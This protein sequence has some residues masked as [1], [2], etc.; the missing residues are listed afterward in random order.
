MTLLIRE[1][2]RPDAPAYVAMRMGDLSL[3]V[4]R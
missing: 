3:S 1:L 4:R 2:T